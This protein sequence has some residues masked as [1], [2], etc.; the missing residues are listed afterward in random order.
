MNR[1]LNFLKELDNERNKTYY[2]R[3]AI[4]DRDEKIIKMIE[5]EVQDGSSISI[6][7]NSAVRRT[8]NLTLIAKNETNDLKNI[9][10]Y[11]S[12]N[13]KIKISVG[14]EKPI[15]YERDVHGY[16]DKSESYYDANDPYA[17]GFPYLG[18]RG[19]IYIDQKTLTYWIWNGKKY[20]QIKSIY[21]YKSDIVW[22]PV[23]LFVI[24]QPSFSHNTGSCTISLSC[25]DKMCLL[26]GELGGSFPAPVTFS[27]YY[28]EVG[29]LECSQDPTTDDS[30]TPNEYTIYKYNDKAYIWSEKYGWQENSGE[31]MKSL[32]EIITIQQ[33]I[34]D[35][36]QTSVCNYGHESLS[37]I[38]VNDVPLKIKQ[39]VR[40]VGVRPIYVNA[41]TGEYSIDDHSQDEM[42]TSYNGNEDVGYVYTDF[43]Y[44]LKQGETLQGNIG[45]NVCT[46]LDKI[47]NT[48][49]N[50]EYFYDVDGNFIFQE[51]KNYL[52]NSYDLLK[53]QNN[54][55]IYYLDNNKDS[56]VAIEN[57]NLMVIGKENYRAD[58]CGDSLSVYTFEEGS[59]L[60][61]AY[62]NTP[63][64]SNI[65]ND[66]HIWGQNQN[67]DITNNFHYHFAIKTPPSERKTRNVV[68]LQDENGKYNGKLRLAE[69]GETEFYT[70]TPEDWRAELYL[71]GL[72]LKAVGDR[73][74][75]YQ[76]ELLDK[77]DII[78]E[79][80][81]YDGEDFI[82]RG[83][84]KDS[85]RNPNSLTYFIDFMPPIDNLYSIAV[86]DIGIKTH[87]QKNDRIVK[88]YNVDV[89]N[90]V[91]INEDYS[92]EYK[93][94]IIAECE[95]EGQDYRIISSVIFKDIMEGTYG[96]SAQEV[97]RD[98]I[99]QYSGYNESITLQSI[100]IYYLDTNKRI[101]VK[102]KISNI[103]GDFVIQ[104]I[105]LPLSAGTS[106]SI[107]ASRALNRI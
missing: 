41:D 27:E 30:I 70:Y 17:H 71:Q 76:Q 57:N 23:G 54:T 1:E 105:T 92:E 82:E 33:L 44:P 90:Y 79:F 95:K 12:I 91:L 34:Y 46:I 31:D 59:G 36:I 18:K 6:N 50:F 68:F 101:T 47:K 60:I 53:E 39:L 69:P 15:N 45:E 49:G 84:F 73:P 19:N 21:D 37:R 29:S 2:A 99:Y 72:E 78:Y 58:Y 11:L 65:K 93:D 38:V 103:D 55:I 56:T 74:D 40:N 42:W 106:M 5:G 28:Q 43:V 85:V 80:G 75:M 35:I 96:Y 66:Y 64:Y 8:C 7:G 48:L 100:P 10:H 87:S 24:V 51:I 4:L 16:K 62:S 26:N 88:L 22:F 98:T 67:G 77:L 14:V 13:K 86:D 97:L 102:D 9:N 81:Y 25:K 3:I 83:R 63:S 89:P 52:N 94:K 104:T 20:E 32:G 61:S 107:T